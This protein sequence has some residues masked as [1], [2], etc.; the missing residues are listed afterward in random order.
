MRHRRRASGPCG[1]VVV[2]DPEKFGKTGG[3]KM[4]NRWDQWGDYAALQDRL[5]R[6][7]EDA[8]HRRGDASDDEL[9]HADW[10]PASDVVEREGEFVIVLDLPGIDRD[11]LDVSVN[12]NRLTVRGER[13][14]EEGAKRRRSNRP[15]GRFLARF[16]P[17]PNTVDQT[18][19]AAEYKDGV[20]RLRLPKRTPEQAGRLKI[21][22]R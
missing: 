5:N 6:L 11:A 18:K 15:A 1:H 17:L 9:E 20:L 16:G 8:S 14:E 19:I 21:E 3:K 22:I 10:T 13:A 7:F 2:I 12:E 4:A